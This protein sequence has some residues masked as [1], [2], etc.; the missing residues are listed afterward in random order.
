MTRLLGA[1]AVL[2][3]LACGD[4][5]VTRYTGTAMNDAMPDSASRLTL[6][7][8]SRTD[9]S[10]AGVLELGAPLPGTG[11]AY[12]WHAGPA[13]KIVTVAATGDTIIWTSTRSDSLVGGRF[14]VTGGRHEGQGGTW[15]AQL[16]K[17]PPASA[18]TLRQPVRPA[19]A[20]V[21]ALWSVLLLAAI[22]AATARWVRAAPR[23]S[24]ADVLAETP[25]PTPPGRSLN[26]IGGW[27][28]FFVVAQG[29]G[30]LTSLFRI[31]GS[32]SDYR[33]SI[34]VGSLVPGMQAL[35]VLETV[36][37]L[38]LPA[39]LL[40]G[41]V[42]LLKRNAQAPRFWF[43]YLALSAVYL[44]LDLALGRLFTSQLLALV[45]PAVAASGA[46][47][48]AVIRQA[49][50]SLLW[51]LYWAHSLRVRATFGAT[52]LD[53]TAR[54]VSRPVALPV[55]D[56]GTAAAPRPRRSRLK[57]AAI[58]VGAIA[59]ILVVF[60]AVGLLTMYV[61]P[62]DVP[63]GTD[64]RRVVAGRWDWKRHTKLCAD[65]AHVIAFPGD[66]KVMTITQQQRW[67]DSLGTDRTTTTYDVLRATTSTI[68]GAIRGEDRLT[69]D[70]KPVVWD[71]V[72]VGP[73]E[74]R[75]H[76]TDWMS[77]WGYTGPIVRCEGAAPAATSAR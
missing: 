77:G 48:T 24:A 16:A 29:V 26:G 4:A 57:I 36:L 66:G 17:G 52:A 69:D 14:E 61:R 32:V 2:C 10:F 7:F 12:A 42:L 58:T 21:T 35:I 13:L 75:W 76:R 56:G 71:L 53:T 18:S 11:P 28:L 55:V 37:H 51:V 9:T 38:L 74:Y 63:A 54:P 65:S 68:R 20:P 15:R 50:F 30:L 70:G 41:M 40:L 3:V 44:L 31:P 6:T 49:L 8:Y 27:L 45:G 64:V 25:P 46:S 19:G 73:D 34:G 67:V 62:Y 59:G 23:A 22:G 33:R 47:N 5:T 72:L 60:A 43:A 39:I 1:V